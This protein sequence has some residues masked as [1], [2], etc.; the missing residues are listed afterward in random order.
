MKPCYQSHRP[1]AEMNS[2]K[3]LILITGAPE[4]VAYSALERESDRGRIDYGVSIRTAWVT[5]SGY[6]FLKDDGIEIK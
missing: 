3:I 5:P 2:V 4:K 1:G 6:E